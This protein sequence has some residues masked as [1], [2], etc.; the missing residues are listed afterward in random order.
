MR[1]GDLKYRPFAL[2]ANFLAAIS[3]AAIS[4]AAYCG[5][6]IGNGYLEIEWSR[7]Q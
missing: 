4:E 5:D 2:A 7:D 1:S 6:P 3:S